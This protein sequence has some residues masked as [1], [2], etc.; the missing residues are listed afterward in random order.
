MPNFNPTHVRFFTSSLTRFLL[1]MCKQLGT[2]H[3]RFPAPVCDYCP[4]FG[5]NQF[6]SVAGSFLSATTYICTTASLLLP[7][8]PH[9]IGETKIVTSSPPAHL[10]TN[11]S[12]RW[13]EMVSPVMEPPITNQ[14]ANDD[15]NDNT[16]ENKEDGGDVMGER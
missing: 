11:T 7:H 3:R 14:N 9:L 16:H 8:F 10:L 1:Y 2:K 12:A 4:L 6:N 15:D 5:P 13:R